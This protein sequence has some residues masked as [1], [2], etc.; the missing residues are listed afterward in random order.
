MM[1]TGVGARRAESAPIGIVACPFG[2]GR[3]QAPDVAMVAC[4][5]ASAN[6]PSGLRER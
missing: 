3:G 6:G 2:T 1:P 5:K 4:H